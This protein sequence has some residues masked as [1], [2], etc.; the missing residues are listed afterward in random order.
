MSLRWANEV[1]LVV[2]LF[3]IH[4]H[5]VARRFQQAHHADRRRGHG[6]IRSLVIKLTLP[7]VTGVSNLIQASPIPLMA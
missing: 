4:G 1:Y 2:F 3:E 7:P 6:T 5:L